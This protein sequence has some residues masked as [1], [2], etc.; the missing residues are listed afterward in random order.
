[1][2]ER[3]EIIRREPQQNV[4]IRDENGAL[5]CTV[6]PTGNDAE[7]I[8]RAPQLEKARAEI[9]AELLEFTGRT[10]PV[11]DTDPREVFGM[12]RRWSAI[13]ELAGPEDAP[14]GE[15]GTEEA[16]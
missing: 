10:T 6:H 4:E 8:A 2:A 15:V 1:M 5:V 7:L 13:L 16:P 14:G 11:A 12:M 3:W 9:L